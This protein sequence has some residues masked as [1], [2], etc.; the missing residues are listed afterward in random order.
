[1]LK[2]TFHEE[3]GLASWQIGGVTEAGNILRMFLVEDGWRDSTISNPLI[4][5]K[6][7]P[8]QLY[9]VASR[10]LTWKLHRELNILDAAIALHLAMILLPRMM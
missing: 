5:I 10:C 1:M 3:L 8:L 2:T 9:A 7:L 4:S 6:K